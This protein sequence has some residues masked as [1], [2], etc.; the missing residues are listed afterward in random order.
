MPDEP[1]NYSREALKQKDWQQGSLLPAASPI[2][3]AIW[4]SDKEQGWTKARKDAKDRARRDGKLTDPYIYER[5][6]KPSDRLALISFQACDVLK[7]ADEFPIVEFALVLETSTEAVIREADS[8]TSARYFRLG[9]PDGHP[10]A[11]IMDVRFKAQADKGVLVEHD[12]DNTLVSQMPH[13]RRGVFRE[14]LGRR[15]GREAVPDEDSNLIVEPI[16]SAWKELSA[17]KPDLAGRWGAMTSELR[18]R[19]AEDSRLRL[20]I[21]THEAM[22]SSDPDLLEMT[23]WIVDTI[24]WPE[25]RVDITVTD[26]WEITVG[27]HRTTHEIDL[28]WAS[29][30]EGETA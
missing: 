12:P 14:W 19:R 11:R 3:P 17:E 9:D 5:P 21:I 2:K 8:L 23:N 18:F 15:L 20:Y 10:P 13:P 7:P 24:D 27:E 26:V 22:D 1:S 29:Y 25:G 28:A 6:P 4:V 30:E 16:R